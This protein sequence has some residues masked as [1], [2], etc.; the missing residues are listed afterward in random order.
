[1]PVYLPCL[2][3]LNVLERNNITEKCPPPPFILFFFCS[4]S[5]W[6]RQPRLSGMDCAAGRGLASPDSLGASGSNFTHAQHCTLTLLNSNLQKQVWSWNSFPLFDCC[7]CFFVFFFKYHTERTE[8]HKS[9]FFMHCVVFIVLV[10]VVVLPP[11][12]A[13]EPHGLDKSRT[14][15]SS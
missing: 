1:M 13:E 11:G 3:T 9:T 5:E 6:T 12:G 10:F 4:W 14:S 15:T 7:C 8:H 2:G